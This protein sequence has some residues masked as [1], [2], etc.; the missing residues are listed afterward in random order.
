MGFGA[1]F[2][3]S[4]NDNKRWLGL[5][6]MGELGSDI[7]QIKIKEPFGHQNVEL[8][9]LFQS[10]FQTVLSCLRCTCTGYSKGIHLHWASA[11]TVGGTFIVK[12]AP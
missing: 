4:C 6:V 5:A 10:L 12:Y 2:N 7:P 1:S 8:F 11:G 3:T 9:Q